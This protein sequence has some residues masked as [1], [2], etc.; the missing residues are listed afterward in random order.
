MRGRGGEREATAA[1]VRAIAE[2]EDDVDVRIA[3]VLAYLAQCARGRLWEHK[4]FG[5]RTYAEIPASNAAIA[6]FKRQER[7]LEPTAL[8]LAD[9]HTWDTEFELGLA[10]FRSRRAAVGITFASREVA[11]SH[12][13]DVPYRPGARIPGWSA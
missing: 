12:F 7:M 1:A 5:C 3:R 13:D 10:R 4:M 6:S 11:L 8:Q 9:E 2:Q